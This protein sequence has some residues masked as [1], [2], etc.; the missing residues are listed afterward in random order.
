[1]ASNRHLGRIVALQ[2][3]YEYDFRSE[4]TLDIDDIVARNLRQYEGVIG[5]SDF[6]YSLAHAV[7]DNQKTLDEYIQPAA[8]EW[9]V[10]QIARVDKIILRMSVSELI[11]KQDTPPKVVINEA[12]ELGKRFGSDNSSKFVNGVLGTVYREHIGTEQETAESTE[13]PEG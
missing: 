12:V 10:E 3:L 1:M 2:S 4:E 11:F 7:L 13:A 8:P 5:D 9:P 6:V